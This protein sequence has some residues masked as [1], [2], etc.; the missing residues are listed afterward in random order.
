MLAGGGGGEVYRNLRRKRKINQMA[1]FLNKNMSEYDLLMPHGWN[2][3]IEN[4]KT[5]E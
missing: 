5:H 2:E 3:I 4:R 1:R